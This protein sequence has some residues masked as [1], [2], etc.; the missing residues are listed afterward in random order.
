MH[1]LNWLL[2]PLVQLTQFISYRQNL[3]RRVS[4]DS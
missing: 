2:G 1:W 4:Y 3:P